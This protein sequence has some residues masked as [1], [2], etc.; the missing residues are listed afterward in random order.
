MCSVLNC[1]YSHGVRE[2][3]RCSTLS[4]YYDILLIGKLK[5]LFS[6]ALDPPLPP[7]PSHFGDL[8]SAAKFTAYLP[9]MMPEAGRWFYTLYPM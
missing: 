1:E 8:Q 2:I 7:A 6:M 9:V 3:P 5:V 4:W